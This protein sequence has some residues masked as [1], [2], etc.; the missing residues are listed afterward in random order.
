MR[1][2]AVRNPPTRRRGVPSD[3]QL[4]EEDVESVKNTAQLTEECFRNPGTC[5]VRAALRVRAVCAAMP[6]AHAALACRRCAARRCTWA[7][8]PGL[9][10]TLQKADEEWAKM[11]EEERGRVHRV[12]ERARARARVERMQTYNDLKAALS[13]TPEAEEAR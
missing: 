7:Q 10:F 5:Q 6:T 3:P 2:A 12:H 8:I 11:S 13:R 9:A 4:T 1:C